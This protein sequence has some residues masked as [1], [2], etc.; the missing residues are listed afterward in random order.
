V[1]GYQLNGPVEK[2]PYIFSGTFLVTLSIEKI[3]EYK[4]MNVIFHTTVAL[5]TA[6]L[7]TDTER[8]GANPAVRKVVPAALSAFVAGIISHGVLDYVPHCYPVNS[9][10]DAVVAL[11]MIVAATW[12][13]HGAY[14]AIVGLSFLGSVFPD[15][16][17]LGP[18]IVNRQL[19][20]G[21]TLP[22]NM[23]PWHWHAWSGSV[24][25]G[26]CHV[27]TLNHFLLVFTVALV[28]WFRRTD[29]SVIFG[30]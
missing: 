19:N 22:D 11:V 26:D 6:V 8:I 7:V 2:N 21:L 1:A 23:F 28:V 17:D 16:I 9:K 14:R 18:K 4:G 20:L 13:A 25:S 15:L 27:S 29:F 3:D 5:G 30:R 12:F 24:Y 10:V